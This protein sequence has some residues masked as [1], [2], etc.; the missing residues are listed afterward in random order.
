M[1]CTRGVQCRS[2]IDPVYGVRP[3]DPSG[4]IIMTVFLLMYPGIALR[5][6]YMHDPEDLI[7]FIDPESSFILIEERVPIL[8]HRLV[9]PVPYPGHHL[10]HSKRIFATFVLRIIE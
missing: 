3:R 2:V 7:S 8:E 6:C 4:Q 10:C 9:Q 1:R 5:E